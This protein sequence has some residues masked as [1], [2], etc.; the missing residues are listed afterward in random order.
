MVVPSF[1]GGGVVH[2]GPMLFELCPVLFI[3]LFP[4]VCGSYNKKYHF[5]PFRE[6]QAAEL[7]IG[8]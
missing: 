2:G 5:G 1:P 3:L 6:T 8:Q 4:I 7:G